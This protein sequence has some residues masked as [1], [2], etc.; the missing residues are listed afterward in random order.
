MEQA[1]KFLGLDHAI[2]LPNP[3]YLVAG[4]A[5]AAFLLDK[6]F[7]HALLLAAA[8]FLLLLVMKR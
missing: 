2:V 3:L 5:C 6:N 8:V 1:V 4:V 7:K